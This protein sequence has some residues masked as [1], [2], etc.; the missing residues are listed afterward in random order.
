MWPHSLERSD[1]NTRDSHITLFAR[2]NP[3]I[4][5]MQNTKGDSYAFFGAWHVT[6][7]YSVDSLHGAI[8]Y[9]EQ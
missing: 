1:E 8:A 6:G 7:R 9:V 4:D 5:G 2:S 3:I